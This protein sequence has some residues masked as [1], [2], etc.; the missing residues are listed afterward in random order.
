MRNAMGTGEA[1]RIV[2]TEG[3]VAVRPPVVGAGRP[4]YAGPPSDAWAF[5]TVHSSI[6]FSVRRMLVARVRGQFTKWR[7]SMSFDPARPSAADLSV[8]IEAASIDT[9]H[10]DRDAH[11]RSAD[12][13]DVERHPLVTFKSVRV[14]D[15]GEMR[16]AID[17]ALE[18]RGETREVVLR[19]DYR[20]LVR[21]QWGNDHLGFAATARIARSDFGL[22]WNEVLPTGELFVGEEVE[23]SIEIQATRLPPRAA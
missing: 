17:G 7:G 9:G 10:P 19:A 5:D 6:F 18:I 16:F 23:I 11:L 12:F 20:G 4:V 1:R 8:R 22:R 15:L 21:D 3:M 13:L 14:R 2:V